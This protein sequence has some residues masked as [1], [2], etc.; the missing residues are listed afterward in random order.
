MLKEKVQALAI[1]HRVSRDK[2][3]AC[4]ADQQRSLIINNVK[5][6]AMFGKTNVQE[7]LDSFETKPKNIFNLKWKQLFR[8]LIAAYQ[9]DDIQ[10][11]RDLNTRLIEDIIQVPL[12]LTGKFADYTRWRFSL[13]NL[14]RGQGAP[15]LEHILDTFDDSISKPLIKALNAN[16]RSQEPLKRFHNMILEKVDGVNT[17]TTFKKWISTLEKVYY[18]FTMTVASTHS[19]MEDVVKPDSF[20]KKGN[21]SGPPANKYQKPNGNNQNKSNGNSKPSAPAKPTD[22]PKAE[23]QPTGSDTCNA[24]GKPH[25]NKQC[26]FVT[27]NHPDVNKSSA[28]FLD[29]YTGSKYK[30]LGMTSLSSTKKLDYAKKALIDYQG[31][32]LR[33]QDK[34]SLKLSANTLDQHDGNNKH[35]TS[36]FYVNREARVNPS[37]NLSASPMVAMSKLTIKQP[38]EQSIKTPMDLNPVEANLIDISHNRLNKDDGQPKATVYLDSGSLDYNFISYKMVYDLNLITCNF[39]NSNNNVKT[40]NGITTIKNM[41]LFHDLLLTIRVPKSSL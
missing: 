38:D 23:S 33:V 32:A 26:F 29:S 1:T 28:N 10:S 31:P 40:I 41:W 34:V 19:L 37:P 14:V 35:E 16:M 4:F 11:D 27:N 30:A 39:D 3:R 8:I 15:S 9:T 5:L 7:L 13:D 18:E 6:T 17:A 36:L 24:C 21:P 2:I 12:K 22:K 25:G 20:K